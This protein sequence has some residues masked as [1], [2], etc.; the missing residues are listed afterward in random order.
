MQKISPVA[1][2]SGVRDF[3]M[4]RRSVVDAILSLTESNRF[5]KGLFAWVG[6]KTHYLDYPNVERQAGKTS[7][8]FRQ[9]FFYSIEG[10]V[11]FSDA[12]LNIAFI[13]GLLSWILAFIMIILI[14]IRTLVFGDPTSGWPSL[15]TVILFLGGFQLLTIGI[16]GKYIGKIFMETKKRPIYVIKE[17]SEE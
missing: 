2:P 5:S 4:M 8:S 15:M 7:W 12:P 1:L 9:L 3:R 17:K 16:L 11:N 6:F 10:I 13:G 14:V